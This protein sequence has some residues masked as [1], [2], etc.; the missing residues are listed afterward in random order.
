MPEALRHMCLHQL[1]GRLG[2]WDEALGHANWIANTMP[3]VTAINNVGVALIHLGRYE[4]AASCMAEAAA[5]PD[6]A[7]YIGLHANLAEAFAGMGAWPE[8]RAT[9]DHA[10]SLADENSAEDMFRLSDAAACLGLYHRAVEMYARFVELRFGIARP[11]E[12][13]P[14]DFIEANEH[15]LADVE[16]SVAMSEA[17]VRVAAR[18]DGR[19]IL[20]AEGS[21]APDDD[22]RLAVL[23]SFRPLRERANRAVLRDA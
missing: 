15:R 19:K 12:M 20:P 9:F 10:V 13:G 1:L 21:D 8:A 2:R 16:A 23:E 4:D 18:R 3:S 11:A 22:D 5:Q 6:S 14:L 7:T 17:A